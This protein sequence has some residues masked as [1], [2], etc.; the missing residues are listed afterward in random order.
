MIV[1]NFVEGVLRH[2][3]IAIEV[4]VNLALVRI[5]VMDVMQCTA[6]NAEMMSALP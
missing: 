5:L 4:V 2:A 3:N 6:K 1:G